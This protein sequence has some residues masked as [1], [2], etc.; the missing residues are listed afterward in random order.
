MSERH[1]LLVTNTFPYGVGEEFLIN[2]MG[3][4]AEGFDRITVVATQVAVGAQ[5]TKDLPANATAINATPPHRLSGRFGALEKLLQGTPRTVLSREARRRAFRLRGGAR[6]ALWS[7]YF[8]ARA[9]AV[10][11]EALRELDIPRLASSDL[12]IYAF[13]FHVAA[14][15]GEIIADDVAVESGRRPRMVMRAHRYDLYEEESASGVIPQ[16]RE[17]LAAY[18][19]VVP[20]SE[21]G[22]HYLRTKYPATAHKVVLHR[23]GTADPGG[24]AMLTRSRYH[25]VSCSSFAEVKRMPLFAPVLQA[26][27]STG[28][29]V[30]WTHIGSGPGA[31]DLLAESR[32]VAPSVDITFAGAMPND[33]VHDRYRT[34]PISVLLNLSSSE[35]VPVSIMEAMSL[36]IPVVATA[37][38]GTAEAVIDGR[39]GVLVGRDDPVDVIAS[40]LRRVWELDDEAY[41]RLCQESRSVWEERCDMRAVYP[42][43]VALLRSEAP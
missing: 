19:A 7:V 28:V 2:E 40:A 32:R 24:R 34:H 17:L 43:F 38:G 22:A 3:F 39:N 20:I 6:A 10:A 30:A 13:W 36:S 29:D 27:T 31:D 33:Q 23:L 37:V 41:D 21:D 16:R 42:P 4:L 35:G 8:E 18:D 15:V 12:T 1:L 5:Q 9:Q 14:R 26:L 11:R 25:V